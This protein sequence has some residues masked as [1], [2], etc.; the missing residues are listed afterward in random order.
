[1]TVDCVYRKPFQL[2]SWWSSESPLH[3]NLHPSLDSYFNVTF[4]YRTDA[5]VYAPYGSIHLI[6]KELRMARDSNLDLLLEKKRNDKVAAWVVSNCYLKRYLYGR[7]LIMLGLKVDTFGLCFDNRELGKGKY[8]KEFYDELSKYKF[9]L[10]FENSIGC[11]DYFT[12]KFW[13]NS[14]RAGVV[15]V[16]WGPKKEDILKVAPTK[17]FI[18]VDDFEHPKKLIQYLN[19]LA[20]NETAYAEYLDWRTWTHSPE[21]I[22][23][24]LRIE[25]RDYDLRSFCKLCSIVQQA[26]KRR[27]L[28]LPMQKRVIPSLH[29]AWLGAEDNCHK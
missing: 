23:S 24:R 28:N 15:P 19:Y 4:H 22:E 3:T 11:K 9:Y 8:S 25:K 12:E 6:L 26:G 2:Y 18:H 21:K 20:S 17:S 14:L 13:Y 29:E 16:V 10:A 5:D 27:K 1:M 7:A